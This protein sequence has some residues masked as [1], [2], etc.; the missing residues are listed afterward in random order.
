M[1]STFGHLKKLTFSYALVLILFSCG[2]SG[3]KQV[4][5]STPRVDTAKIIESM[6]LI[7][8][9]GNFDYKE[10]DEK[11]EFLEDTMRTVWLKYM[12]P[13]CNCMDWC[14]YD[15]DK[16]RTDSVMY[17]EPANIE[18]SIPSYFYVVENVIQFSGKLYKEKGYPQGLVME[19]TMTPKGRVFRYYSYKILKPFR[20]WGP[21]NPEDTTMPLELIVK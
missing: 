1:L 16:G 3:K 18:I 2:N 10:P 11:A 21:G 6:H 20:V 4:I 12:D 19:G 5:E 7:L 14:F 13:A 17:I 15:S 8:Q 9:K